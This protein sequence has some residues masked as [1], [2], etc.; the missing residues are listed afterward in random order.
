MREIER[1]GGEGEGERKEERSGGRKGEGER[2]Q[3]EMDKYQKV[4]SR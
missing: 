2:Q 3:V 4:F 1:R